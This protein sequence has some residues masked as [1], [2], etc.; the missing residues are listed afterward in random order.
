MP[1]DRMLG[2]N[3]MKTEINYKKNQSTIL[4]GCIVL[5]IMMIGSFPIEVR[6]EGSYGY[7]VDPYKEYSYENMLSDAN[8]LQGMYPELIRVKSIGQ[9]V[10]GRDLVLIELGNGDKKVFLNGATHAREYITT[11]YLMYMIDRYAYAYSMG[12]LFNGYD[13]TRILNGVTFNIIPMVNPD[14][15]NL[16]QNGISSVKDYD[17]VSKIPINKADRHGYTS[18]KA[19]INGVDLNRNYPDS[20][21]GSA[22]INAPASS[23][24]RG[25]SPLSEPESKAIDQFLNVNMFWAYITFH[26]QGESIYG[27][28]DSN[29]VFYPELNAMVSRII[30]DSGYIKASG[31]AG[32]TYGSFAN[33]VRDIYLKP[34]LTIELCRYVGSYPY[35]NEEFDKVWNPTRNICLIVADEVLKMKTQDYLVYQ[36]SSLLNAFNNEKYAL[37]YAKKWANAKVLYI[38]DVKE[39]VKTIMPVAIDGEIDGNKKEFQAYSIDGATFIKLRDF[40][41]VFSNT[42]KQ[43]EVGYD[44]INNAVTITRGAVYTKVGIESSL[45]S[46]TATERVTLSNT[47]LY[48]DGSNIALLAYNI[49]GSNYFDLNDISSVLEMT[50]ETESDYFYY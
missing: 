26:S 22:T 6:A 14:G 39:I 38:K 41:E 17:K 35:P 9:S 34:M 23:N 37:A 28:N 18:W 43:F 27:W 24:F 12:G 19:N 42:E 21:N 2:D 49:G 16:V 36:N 40:A 3:I 11:T 47:S 1:L 13:M 33:Y 48:L 31:A 15:V 46:I 7:V 30:N 50:V 29:A 44:N 20:W 32:P 25:Y 4:I 8:T 45:P 5:T 10:E